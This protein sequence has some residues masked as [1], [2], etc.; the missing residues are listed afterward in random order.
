MQSV[1]NFCPRCGKQD[2]DTER[3][4]SPGN[5]VC[6]A[7]GTIFSVLSVP[8]TGEHAI[9]ADLQAE[10]AARAGAAG[11]TTKKEPSSGR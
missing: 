11:S 8:T 2:I 5:G 6:R 10:N 3:H 4:G 9:P 1:L 7:C